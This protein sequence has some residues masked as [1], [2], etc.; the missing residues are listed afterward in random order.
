MSVAPTLILWSHALAALLFGV[1]ALRQIQ[2]P[3]PGLPPRTLAVALSVTAL[4]ALAVAGI[5]PREIATRWVESARNLAWLALL[6]VVARRRHL[7]IALGALYATVGLLSVA[8]AGLGIVATLPVPGEVHRAVATAW[9]L[10]RLM[11]AVGMLL[12]VHDAVGRHDVRN[13]KLRLVAFALATIWGVDSVLF[14]T[15]YIA[16]GWP[17]SLV[18]IR[19]LVLAGVAALLGVAL[20]RDGDREP[21]VSRT[22]ALRLLAVAAA[23]LYVGT[24]VILTNLAAMFAGEYARVAQTGIVFGATAALL[25]LISTPWLRAWARVKVAKH[26][27]AHRYDYREEWQRFTETLGRPGAGTAP[28][29]A[30]IVKAVADLTDSP[31]GLLLVPDG[32]G[33]GASAVWNREQPDGPI[34]GDEALA[35]YLSYTRRIIELDAVRTATVS[36]DETATV[37]AWVLADR[38]AWVIV[39]LVHG[40]T[41]A[42]AVLLARP[43]VDRALDWEDFDLLRVAGRQAASYLEEDRA[44][45]ALADAERFDE[46]NRRFAFILHD[47]KNLVSQQSLV[48]HNVERHAD[49]PAFRTDMVATLKDSAT[50]MTALLARLSPIEARADPPRPV[51]LAPLLGRIAASRRARH[52]VV[53]R[54]AETLVV[55]ADPVR[56]EQVLSHLVQNATEASGEDGAVTIDA[57][58]IDGR[59]AIDVVDHG[60]GMTPE[61]VRDLLFRPFVSTKPGGFGIGAYEA[62]Q[63]V[64]AMNGTLE[65][66]SRVGEGT[67]FRILLPLAASLEAAA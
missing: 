10:F 19:G 24:I 16:G 34:A 56:L 65:V 2:R 11:A 43:P 38:D 54:S 30:R 62:R 25:T 66:T 14:A 15:A 47:I 9:L 26:L 22:A 4:W 21:G 20:D 31:A 45:A 3:T 55:Q 60:H 6:V 18:A 13:P 32:A 5:D 52:P 39:P 51:D 41:L 44:R 7:G 35:T 37:P 1:L 48:A 57:A 29:G 40:E 8:S 42:G 12:L 64:A 33:F 17:V 53:C 27:F 63:L 23:A 61:F 59:I 49:N 50:R 58:L 28:L 36:P 67:R 46:F